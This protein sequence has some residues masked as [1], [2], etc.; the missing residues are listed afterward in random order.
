MLQIEQQDVE[1]HDVEQI[2][3]HESKPA[4]CIFALIEESQKLP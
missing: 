3:G 4:M 1:H 2:D